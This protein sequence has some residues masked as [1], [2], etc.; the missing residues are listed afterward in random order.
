LRKI[1]PGEK[2][3]WKYLSTKKIGYWHNISNLKN[4][5]FNKINFRKLFFKNLYKIGYR[6]FDIKKTS[7]HDMKVVKAFQRRFRQNNV[8][9][10]IDQECL[11]ISHFLANSLKN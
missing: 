9:G 5:N 1:D 10:L 7:K 6:Y 2:F 3:P 8:N 11:K 4:N